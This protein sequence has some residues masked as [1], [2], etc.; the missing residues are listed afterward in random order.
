[1]KKLLIGCLIALTIGSLIGCTNEKVNYETNTTADEISETQK[2][3]EIEEY[4]PEYVTVNYENEGFYQYKIIKCDQDKIEEIKKNYKSSPINT[5]ITL[6]FTN[7]NEFDG[8]EKKYG[9]NE[10]H[11]YITMA[12][13]KKIEFYN[14]LEKKYIK[15]VEP[16]EMFDK[17]YRKRCFKIYYKHLNELSTVIAVRCTEE[18][19][20]YIEKTKSETYNEV[21]IIDENNNNIEG[22]IG[23]YG[24]TGEKIYIKRSIWD[25]VYYY[26]VIE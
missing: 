25:S 18:E 2:T 23:R 14:V 22:I 5:L 17:N 13:G 1:M 3:N 10:E 15:P 20:E 19:V 4:Q 21:S 26:K 24:D 8:F 16:E 11:S 12:N 7:G 9:Q 6:K